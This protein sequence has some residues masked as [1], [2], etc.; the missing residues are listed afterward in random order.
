[1]SSSLIATANAIFRYYEGQNHVHP[2]LVDD[3][4]ITLAPQFNRIK[5]V[6]AAAEKSSFVNKILTPLQTVHCI[7]HASLDQLFL[8]ELARI[9]AAQVV[10]LGA[11]LDSRRLRFSDLLNGVVWIEVDRD[12]Q[13]DQKKSHFE[14]NYPELDIRFI[15][16]DLDHDMG[17]MFWG[18]ANLDPDLP[19]IIIAEG[20]IHY[21]QREIYS[22]L[23][24]SFQF[25]KGH[26]SFIFSFITP[27][28]VRK[29]RVSLKFLFGYFQEIP[30][31]FLSESEMESILLECGFTGVEI[32]K[33][34]DQIEQFAPQAI[35]RDMNVSQYVGLATK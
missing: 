8:R 29:A 12:G 17:P 10:V 6:V 24:D 13:Q 31:L 20:L 15:S 30:S 26:Q 22:A 2:I 16:K 14:S 7:R 27:A 18:E 5:S 11:G 25:F 19:T 9:Q 23:L 33:L 3:Y 1:M 32:L 4:S 28:M 35:D 34:A 21:L